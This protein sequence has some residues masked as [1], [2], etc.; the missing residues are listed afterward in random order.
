MPSKYTF[1]DE[2]L[3]KT[4]YFRLKMIDNDGSF[5]YSKVVSL[6]VQSKN[7]VKITP[8]VSDETVVVE[9]DFDDKTTTQIEIYNQKGQLMI[10]KTA[11][12][13]NTISLQNLP[14]G[15][16]FVRVNHGSDFWVKKIMKF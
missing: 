9:T 13:T 2:K 4:T 8:S 3:N 5:D 12:N 6:F 10:K 16:Y 1:S 15:I 7:T 14:Q 11:L